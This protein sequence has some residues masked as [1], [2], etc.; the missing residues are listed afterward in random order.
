LQQLTIPRRD[1]ITE[2]VAALFTLLLIA[3]L[4][5]STRLT[6]CGY[7]V[8]RTETIILTIKSLSKNC[9]LNLA[10]LITLAQASAFIVQ[11]KVRDMSAF[12]AY[13]SNKKQR[14]SAQ[15]IR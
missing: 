11:S 4:H 3:V 8:N 10:G 12:K 2:Y 9:R 14:V 5:R 7:H 1:N 15:L 6:R 13:I